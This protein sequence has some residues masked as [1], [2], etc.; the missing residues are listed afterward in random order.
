MTIGPAIRRP[1]EVAGGIA[2]TVAGSS[3][4]MEEG[5]VIGVFILAIRGGPVGHLRWMLRR[6]A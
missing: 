6:R 1:L 3:P 4:S 5:L 2:S